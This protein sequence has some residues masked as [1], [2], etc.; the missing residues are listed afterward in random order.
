MRWHACTRSLGLSCAGIDI[1]RTT[2]GAQQYH[3]KLHCHHELLHCCSLAFMAQQHSWQCGRTGSRTRSYSCDCFEVEKPVGR[4]VAS[5]GC[6]GELG[7]VRLGKRRNPVA[8]RQARVCRECQESDEQIATS[9]IRPAPPHVKEL[10]VT[11]DAF[12]TSHSAIYASVYDA[13]HPPIPCPVVTSR[14][15]RFIESFPRRDNNA[16]LRQ[17]T[18]HHGKR[19]HV[20][21]SGHE[22]QQPMM[23]QQLLQGLAMLIQGGS[24]GRRQALEDDIPVVKFPMAGEADIPVVKFP[25]AGEVVPCEKP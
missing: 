10:P 11:A 15:R 3:A 13:S 4:H 23:M 20:P 5:I 24:H 9:C 14:L 21:A 12:R 6:Y 7:Y 2:L 8:V 16:L 18:V 22:Q 17:S 25:M 1:S 19:L